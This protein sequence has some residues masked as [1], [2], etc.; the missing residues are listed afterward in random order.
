MNKNIRS[1]FNDKNLYRFLAYFFNQDLSRL[2]KK[3]LLRVLN[4]LIEETNGIN[5]EK[6][7]FGEPKIIELIKSLD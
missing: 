1:S 4:T 2:D 3:G 7:A 5:K 6:I